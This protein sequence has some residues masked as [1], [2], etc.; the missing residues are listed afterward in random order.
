MPTPSFYNTGTAT[1]AALG[2]AVTGQGTAWLNSIRPGDLFGTHKGAG[3]RV[4]TVNSNTSLTLAY[5]WTGGAQT[6]A[7]YEIA[8]TPDSARMQETT[9]QLLELLTNGTLSSFA[10][11]DGTGGDK[12]VMLSGAG[13]AATFP[14]T[15]YARTLLDDANNTDARAT[16]LA[17]G[18]LH[19]VTAITASTTHSFATASKSCLIEVL[20][21]GGGGAGANPTGATTASAGAGGGAG[22]YA[23]GFYAI[24]ASTT[25]ANVTVGAAGSGGSA[26]TNGGAGGSSSCSAGGIS[27]LTGGGG[28]GGVVPQASAVTMVRSGGTGGT[29]SGGADVNAPGQSGGSSYSHGSTINSTMNALSGQGAASIYGS[30]GDAV[31]A[32]GSSAAGSAGGAA[33]GYGAGGGGASRVGDAN[34]N[35]GGNG[36]PGLVIIWEF[37]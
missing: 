4:L 14:L 34:T 22:G 20:G 16:L 15:A 24:A 26:G 31:T 19:R 23:R 27:A 7:A 6:T 29:A 10:G 12:G 13:V 2:T 5:A 11:L 35:S 17:T 33:S 9:R 3:I 28:G 8:I 36:A 18:N 30:G 37:R 32:R 21:G 25:I 1:V